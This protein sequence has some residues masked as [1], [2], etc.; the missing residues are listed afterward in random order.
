MKR[1]GLLLLALLLSS[2]FSLY[3]QSSTPTA[4][5]KLRFAAVVLDEKGTPIRDLRSDDFTIEVMGKNQPVQ[6]ES[7]AA[8]NAADARGLVVVVIDSMHMRWSEEKDVRLSTGKYLAQCAKRNVPVSLLVFARDGKL[9]PVHEYTISSTTL[10]A[11]LERAD[12]E[13]SRQQ[14]PANADKDVIAE[15]SRFVDFY[16][17]QGDFPSQRALQEYPGAVLEG[18]KRVALYAAPV[19]GRK[20][21]IWVASTFPFAVEEKQGR[22]LSPTTTSL[23]PGDLIYPNLLTPDQVKK[24]QVVWEDSIGTAQSLGLA[25]YPVQTRRTATVDL[26]PEVINSMTSLAHMTGGVEVHTVGDFYGQL[27]DLSEQ[28]RAA[29]DL[30]ITADANWDCK[31]DW[32]PVRITVHRPGARVLAPQ[33]FFREASLVRSS[34]AVATTEAS[35]S[36]A[37]AAEIPFT[38]NFKPAEDAGAKKKIAFVVTVGSAAGIPTQGSAELDVEV[39]VHAFANGADKQGL[40]F[41]AKAQLPPQKVDEIR[42]KGFALNNS[43]ELEPGDYEVRFIVHDKVSGRLGMIKVPLRVVSQSG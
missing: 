5:A 19:P 7:P 13:M 41:G 15:A 20:S 24:L 25:L 10:A 2:S 22:I 39:M 32:C 17:G 43:I 12:A 33:G 14:P 8:A 42:S 4:P 30:T 3:C 37:P 40:S 29:Y 9:M 26:N 28:S 23:A 36:A 21:L 18:F 31:N 38:V 11:A 34:S 35:I 6:V 27:T 16:K 1:H